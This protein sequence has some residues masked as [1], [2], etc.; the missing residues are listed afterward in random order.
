MARA[1]LQVAT[2]LAPSVL[3]LYR[4]ATRAMA[5]RLGRVPRLTVAESYERCAA[6]IDD[7]CFVCSV[8]YLLFGQA[9]RMQMEV[10]AAPVLSGARYGGRP[11]YFSDII[12]RAEGHLSGFDD[13]RGA[14]WAYNEP[15][16]HSGHLVVLHELAARG[17]TVGFFGEMIEAGFHDE[18][19]RMVVAGE[20][21][22]AAID[23]QILAIAF[24]RQPE[25]RTRVRIIGALGPSTIQPVVAS[26]RR[27]APEERTALRDVLLGLHLDP[28]A[29]PVLRA[30]HVRGFVAVPDGYS[31][32]A[33]MFRRVSDGGLLDAA[34]WH[35][36]E[37]ASTPDLARH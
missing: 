7:V 16:S 32:I 9:G 23:S 21:D 31:D 27:L 6:E 18:A 28:A 22:A 13:L 37:T 1:T 14:R 26:V 10:L 12:V 2:H 5:A 3:P 33:A 34:W 29:Q 8:P 19:I 24:D 25:L 4:Y 30:A 11:I 15:F 17:E 35:R 20:V 36:W